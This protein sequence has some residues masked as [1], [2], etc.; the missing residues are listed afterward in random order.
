MTGVLVKSEEIFR[1][2]SL[3]LKATHSGHSM[4]HLVDKMVESP[5]VQENLK[6]RQVCAMVTPGLF[7]QVEN[8]C[9]TLGLSKR[10]LLTLALVDVIEKAETILAEVDPYAGRND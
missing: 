7:E 1:L 4:S 5:E 2:K 10:E 8:T 3:Q 9:N 6:L